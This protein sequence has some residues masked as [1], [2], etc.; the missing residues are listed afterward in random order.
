MKPRDACAELWFSTYMGLLTDR[1]VESKIVCVP[2]IAGSQAFLVVEEMR[3]TNKLP[4]MIREVGA[5]FYTH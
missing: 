5:L 4:L 1:Y 2:M 3:D